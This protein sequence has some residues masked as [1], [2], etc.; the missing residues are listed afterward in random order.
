MKANTP[1]DLKLAVI[2]RLSRG[3]LVIDSAVEDRNSFSTFIE[4][5]DIPVKVIPTFTITIKGHYL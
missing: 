5:C 4:D 2:E 3:Y 1:E